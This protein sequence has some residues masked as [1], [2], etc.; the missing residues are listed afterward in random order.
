MP[1]RSRWWLW[2]ES[3]SPT[4]GSVSAPGDASAATARTRRSP[5]DVGGRPFAVRL[6]PLLALALGLRLI[7]AGLIVK[8]NPLV[9]DGLEFHQLAY[10]IAG[11]HG[12]A[13]AEGPRHAFIA[14]ADKPPLY[15]LVLALFTLIGGHGWIP[16]Q[17]AGALIGTGTVAVTGFLGRRVGGDRVGFVAAALAAVYPLLIAADGSFRSESLYALLVTATLLAAY[18]L[19]DRPTLASAAL[20]GALI[21]LATLTRSEAIVLLLLLVL[22][23]ARL[24]RRSWRGALGSTAVA[25]LVALAVLAPWLA[26][27]WIQF[28]R[29]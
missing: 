22:P 5:P 11:G 2:P 14:T 10:A 7:Y 9:G 15:P 28:D 27:D 1:Q 23:V 21:A 25:A 13:L 24:A 17:V 18:R 29:P 8:T 20:C 3:R 26:R 19:L 6:L 12:F 4:C 16:H